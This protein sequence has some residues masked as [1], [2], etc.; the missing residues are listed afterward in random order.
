MRNAQPPSV[1]LH[2]F[3]LG[4]GE[5]H[6]G[7]K[8]QATRAKTQTIPCGCVTAM[9]TPRIYAA[10]RARTPP[11]GVLRPPSPVPASPATRGGG[12]IIRCVPLVCPPPRR[13][14]PLPQ[15]PRRISRRRKQRQSSNRRRR[16]ARR[17]SPGASPTR[18]GTPIRPPRRWTGGTG[19][20]PPLPHAAT[21]VRRGRG[22]RGAP[23][24]P[25]GAP[26]PALAMPPNAAAAAAAA[27]AATAAAAAAAACRSQLPR[28]RGASPAEQASLAAA[29][30]RQA[31]L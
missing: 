13:T 18:G 8:R 26:P 1:P 5:R 28:R 25:V 30:L 7:V 20:C 23:A 11:P 17:T 9:P 21:A 24:A 16:A 2:I 6:A 4:Q 14:R 12:S 3:I 10:R 15:R 19:I 31:W 27:A 29:A 22:G